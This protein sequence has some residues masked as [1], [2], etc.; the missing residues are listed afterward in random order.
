MI[1]ARLPI[2]ELLVAAGLITQDVLEAA[3]RDQAADG[4]RL[5]EI[6]VARKLVTDKQVTQILSHQLALPWVSLAKITPDAA[7]LALVPK[8]LAERHHIVPVYLRRSKKQSTL[9]VATDDPTHEV[10]LRECAQAAQMDICAS[11]TPLQATG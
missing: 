6:L 7:L 10:A 8:A 3:L 4:R 9:Y 2:G 5:G 11:A 1:S